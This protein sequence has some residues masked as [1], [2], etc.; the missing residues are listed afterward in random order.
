MIGF[1]TESAMITGEEILP[2]KL[3]QPGQT[4]SGLSYV[5]P[6]GMR[7]ITIA[8]DNIS[9][10]AGFIQRGDYVDILGFMS[11]KVYGYDGLDPESYK[12][13][14]GIDPLP[15]ELGVTVESATL[16]VAQNIC[17]AAIGTTFANS[18]SEIEGG[19]GS[20]TLFVTPEDALRINQSAKSG[21]LTVVL[22]STGDHEPNTQ[23]PILSNQLIE[24]AK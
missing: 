1:V 17:V 16:V 4:E 13:I 5:I 20:I 9:G 21:I 7:A 11:V 15:E 23:D 18:S 19:Y 22:R 6:E 12:K 3:K 8:V 14:T 10:V 2:A 24:K